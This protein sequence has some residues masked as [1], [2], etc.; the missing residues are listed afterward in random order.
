MQKE[1]TSL[2]LNQYL[3]RVIPLGLALL[4]RYYPLTL[5]NNLTCIL[6]LL[7]YCYFYFYLK[8]LFLF[9][10]YILLSL[11]KDASKKKMQK[12]CDFK[13]YYR[14]YNSIKMTD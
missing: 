9:L 5:E 10:F 4:Y 2:F 6:L 13:D 11:T 14:N 3:L 7:L 8:I 1:L 12:M